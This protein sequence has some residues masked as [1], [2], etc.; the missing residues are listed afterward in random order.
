VVAGTRGAERWSWA[1]A[2]RVK[3]SVARWSW[4]SRDAAGCAVDGRARDGRVVR[5]GGDRGFAEGEGGLGGANFA[6]AQDPA[7]PVAKSEKPVS[8]GEAFTS[9]AR[10]WDRLADGNIQCH[11]CPNECEVKPGE[12]ARAA[13]VR[14]GRANTRR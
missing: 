8:E 6:W 3:R 1:S 13:C 5:D 7:P 2:R 14:I 12:R 9:A 4:A 11:L 10:H